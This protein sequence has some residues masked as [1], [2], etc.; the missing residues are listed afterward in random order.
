MNF[1]VKSFNVSKGERENR[2]NENENHEESTLP[3]EFSFHTNISRK[4]IVLQNETKRET[5][6]VSLT[7]YRHTAMEENGKKEEDTEC[8]DNK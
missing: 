4:S 3:L 2:T 5:V 6:L 7:I 8:P 1:G